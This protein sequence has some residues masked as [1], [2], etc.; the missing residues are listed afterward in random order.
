MNMTTRQKRNEKKEEKMA[1]VC[2]HEIIYH[3]YRYVLCANE[4]TDIKI[5]IHPYLFI[6][7]CLSR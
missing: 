5:K 2:R 6:Y 3:V 1:V 7:Y 4:R